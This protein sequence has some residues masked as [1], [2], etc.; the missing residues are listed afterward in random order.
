MESKSAIHIQDP[1]RQKTIAIEK[2][3]Y[4]QFKQT[5]TMNAMTPTEVSIRF[6]KIE[7]A[8]LRESAQGCIKLYFYLRR[9]KTL[10]V[11]MQ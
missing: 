11:E 9:L 10:I 6:L 3:D 7:S 1:T 8:L 5:E 2:R 4:G